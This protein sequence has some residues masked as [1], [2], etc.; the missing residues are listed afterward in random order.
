MTPSTCMSGVRPAQ[1]ICSGSAG[2]EF[3][4]TDF[5]GMQRAPGT[6]HTKAGPHKRTAKVELA[7]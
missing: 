7:V 5:A 1:L 6:E 3:W 2:H 4:F